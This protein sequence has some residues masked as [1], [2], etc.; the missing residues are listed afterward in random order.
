MTSDV[1]L[2]N[3]QAH[4]KFLL[5]PIPVFD[6]RQLIVEDID[7]EINTINAIR[8]IQLSRSAQAFTNLSGTDKSATYY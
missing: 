2:R 5:T 6:F 7:Q 4:A 3:F 8:V 1:G